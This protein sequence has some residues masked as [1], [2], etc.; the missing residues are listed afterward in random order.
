MTIDDLPPIRR[1]V[2][3]NYSERPSVYDDAPKLAEEIER[4]LAP[5]RQEYDRVVNGWMGDDGTFGYAY[6]AFLVETYHYVKCS[7]QLMRAAWTRLDAR[8]AELRRYFEK[9]IEEERGHEEWVLEDLARLGYDREVVI[10]SQPLA[11]TIEMIGSQM[12]IVEYLRPAGLL[13]YVYVMESRPPNADF[14]C[15]LRQAYSIPSDAMTFLSRHGEADIVH[16]QELREIL[17]TLDRVTEGPVAKVS[18]VLGLAHV[19]RMLLRLRTGGFVTTY[20]SPLATYPPLGED[21][22]TGMATH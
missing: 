3:G 16:S 14:L 20:P 18:A 12:Y 22:I 11:E 19:N 6:P 17:D 7:C 10:G 15:A 4:T 5:Y 21:A 9:H 13:G 2:D 8:R 1:T